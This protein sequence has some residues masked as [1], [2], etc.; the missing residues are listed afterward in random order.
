MKKYVQMGLISLLIVLLYQVPDFLMNLIDNTIGK[1]ILL[2]LCAITYDKYG[3]QTGLLA[4]IVVIVLLYQLQE[5]FINLPK[6]SASFSIGEGMSNNEKFR[7]NKK[8]EAF[9]NYTLS[10]S[11]ISA[12][13]MTDQDRNFKIKSERA[14]FSSSQQSNGFTN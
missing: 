10:P 3:Y 2:C 9:S 1:L 8:K 7:K 13:N 12:T 11:G 14:K 4:G 5:G 6:V